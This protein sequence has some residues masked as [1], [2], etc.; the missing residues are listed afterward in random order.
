MAVFWEGA[1]ALRWTEDDLKAHRAKMKAVNDDYL[2]PKAKILP[3]PCFPENDRMNK[4][5][6]AYAGYLEI[7]KQAGE[8][9]DYRFQPLRLVLAPGGN[10][11]RGVT[12]EPDFLVIAEHLELHDC[13]AIWRKVS[14]KPHIE[15][16]ARVKMF[17][18]ALTLFPWFVFKIAWMDGG[19]W[20]EKV[21]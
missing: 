16:D 5:E 3:R 17:I 14:Q 1:L 10:G 20:C 2:K 4:T 6:R 19:V 9:I 12:Y 15:D 11:E 7:R 13:K 8:I 18:S 21:I